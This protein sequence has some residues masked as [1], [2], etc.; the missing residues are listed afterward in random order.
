MIYLNYNKEYPITFEAL[1]TFSKTVKEVNN[2]I[3]NQD[4][5]IKEEAKDIANMFNVMD[6]EI[7]FTS[8]KYESINLALIGMASANHKKGKNIIVS[9]LEDK[10]VYKI[11][12]YL[13]SIGFEITYV[14]NNEEG[15][16]D[17]DDLKRLVKEDTILVCISA[18]NASMGIRQPLKMIRQIIKKENNNTLFYSDFSNAIGKIAVN[19][20]DVDIA[21]ISSGLI[22]GPKSIGL[23]YK[24][25]P[26]K[27]NHLLYGSNNISVFERYLPLIRSFKI[28]LKESL[29]DLEKKEHFV[30]R[31]N[32]K[33]INA[34]KN[35]NITIN[36]TDYS[37]SHIINITI[38]EN[39]ASYIYNYLTEKDII[40]GYEEGLDTAVMA[41]YNDKKRATNTM[42]IS[43]CY[44]TTTDEIN[45]FINDFIDAYNKY[46]V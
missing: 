32:A 11:C 34:L 15:L 17:F 19:F 2:N 36:K 43:L 31:L 5:L 23:L 30:S 13:A 39:N 1:D 37:V 24:A 6:S 42:M 8:G 9:K 28:A 27:I 33:I 41:V 45:T 35:Y 21:S 20:H 29:N 12:D 3:L 22:G 40:V 44:K 14:N 16:I 46:G 4:K 7:L 38:P 18:V 10:S 26:V 25:E